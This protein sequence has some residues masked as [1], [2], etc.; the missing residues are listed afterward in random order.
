MI[1]TG[2]DTGSFHVQYQAKFQYTFRRVNHQF[3]IIEFKGNP[4]YQGI[5]S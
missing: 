4:N 1:Q 3:G 2:P 5:L